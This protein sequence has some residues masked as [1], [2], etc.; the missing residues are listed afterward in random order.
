ML[1]ERFDAFLLDLD[2]VV[3]VG[4]RPLPG[5]VEALARLRALGRAVRFITNDP[6]PSRAEVAERLRSLGVAADPGEVVSAGWAT[7]RWLAEA[8]VRR[9]FVLGSAGLRAEV[10]A[11]GVAAV[12]EEPEAVVVGADPALT[13]AE[14]ARACLW[15]RRGARFVATNPDLT[16]PTPWGPLPATGAIVRAVEAATGARPTVIGKPEPHLFRLALAGLPPGSRAVMVGD[17]P[18]TDV[19]GARR[20]GIP[21]ILVRGDAGASPPD[22]ARRPDAVIRSLLDLFGTPA[23]A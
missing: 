20:A 9:A 17:N 3:Y 10:E 7:A 11:A 16:F 21:A 13:F 1:A 6:I 15:I 14:V 8:G 12:D 2:G 18:D 19:L 23:T 4:D 5:A 22:D